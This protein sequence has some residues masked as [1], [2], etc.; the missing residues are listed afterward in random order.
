MANV[1][2]AGK[3]TIRLPGMMQAQGYGD[4]VAV[5]TPWTG[6]IVDR[7][8]F[9]APDYAK[10][11]R[12]GNIKVPFGLQPE[13]DYKGAAWYQ[14]DLESRPIGGAAAW[15]SPWSGLTSRPAPGST[16]ARWARQQ[17]VDAPQV[18]AR[19]ERRPG[20]HRLTIRVDNR[21]VVDV[22]VNSHSVTDQPRVTGTGSGAGSSWS[23]RRPSGS[24]NFR[25][26]PTSPPVGDGSRP[27]RQP[28]RKG[29]TGGA[30]AGGR[31]CRHR[32]RPS[33][34]MRLVSLSGRRDVTRGE[35]ARGDAP[36]WTSFNPPF[37]V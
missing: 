6:E 21:L 23:R 33:P 16:T 24:L 9:T 19:H 4:P 18:R 25:C 27:D 22:G 31:L 29:R 34:R 36:L 8:W 12:P 32:D 13:R 30:R 15:F 17:P 26:F 11:R 14:R 10:Y 20:K 35:P 7:S 1:P 3:E 37:T 28:D 5:E 2:L